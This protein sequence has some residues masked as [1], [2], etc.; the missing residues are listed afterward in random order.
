VAYLCNAKFLEVCNRNR[1]FAMEDLQA[2]LEEKK[3]KDLFREL[4]EQICLERPDNVHAFV[5]SY[6]QEKYVDKLSNVLVKYEDD[7]D[8]IVDDDTDVVAEVDEAPRANPANARRR[9]SA[10]SAESVNPDNL[11]NQQK[12]VC[13]IQTIFIYFFFS[14]FKSYTI[15]FSSTNTNV[16][17]MQ[18]IPKTDDEKKRI[19]SLLKTNFL[20]SALDEEAAND[21]INAM[22]EKPFKASDVIMKQGS[23]RKIILK[24]KWQQ[25]HFNLFL[26]L[27]FLFFFLILLIFC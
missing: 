5:V 21:L 7:D 15:D 24:F 13:V 22:S 2:F 6:I 23:K 17:K 10:V 25:N 27:I 12:K 14:K 16:G 3:V 11:K 20:F 8:Q 26:F 9:R 4:M 18:I 19:S 1:F